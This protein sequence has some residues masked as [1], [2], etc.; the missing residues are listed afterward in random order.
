MNDLGGYAGWLA[1]I[2]D[3]LKSRRHDIKRLHWFPFVLTTKRN[4]QPSL[5]IQEKKLQERTAKTTK[6]T[7]R[8]SYQRT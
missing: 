5:E 1:T 3:S 6:R 8:N 7:C 4:R 2:V